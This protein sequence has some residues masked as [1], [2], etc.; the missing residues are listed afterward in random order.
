MDRAAYYRF[1]TRYI[2]FVTDPIFLPKILIPDP[3]L[4]ENFDPQTGKTLLIPQDFVL[5]I[6]PQFQENVTAI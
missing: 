4:D 6:L 5:I 3:K 2:F 1:V